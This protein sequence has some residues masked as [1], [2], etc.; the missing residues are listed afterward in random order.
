MKAGYN[1]VERYKWE[2]LGIKSVWINS[3]S[4]FQ[5]SRMLA[6]E[7]ASCSVCAY[8][9]FHS[10]S[11]CNLSSAFAFT[12]IISNKVSVFEVINLSRHRIPTEE[13]HPVPRRGEELSSTAATCEDSTRHR[14]GG[15][16]MKNFPVTTLL[17]TLYCMPV[18]QHTKT[19]V[20][21]GRPI[22]C[23]LIQDWMLI[24][25]CQHVRDYVILGVVHV[26]SF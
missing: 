13:V 3:T 4:T 20:H 16:Y 21:S 11:Q 12:L 7:R 22:V 1:C 8:Y 5:H 26:F 6:A 2:T 19:R 15:L 14:N 18:C 25:F 24:F 23:S 17:I 9:N 10:L